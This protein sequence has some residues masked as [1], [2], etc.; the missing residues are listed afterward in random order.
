MMLRTQITI[1]Q[2]TTTQT[3][4]GAQVPSWAAYA[5]NIY[6]NVVET[7]GVE[8]WRGAKLNASVTHVVT[9]RYESGLTASTSRK[10][11]VIYGTRTLYVTAV[12]ADERQRWLTLH[13]TEDV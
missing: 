8:Y 11:R 1:Q 13:C 10:M 3:D 2:A 7:G 12:I 6:A 5:T 4:N 9:I